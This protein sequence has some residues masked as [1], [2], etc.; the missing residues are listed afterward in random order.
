MFCKNCNQEI[1]N[2]RFCPF[3]GIENVIPTAEQPVMQQPMMHNPQMQQPVTQQPVMEQNYFQT[4]PVAHTTEVSPVMPAVEVPPVAPANV[5][6]VDNVMPN[7]MPQTPSYDQFVTPAQ[8]N[9]QTD[10]APYS[11]NQN[12]APVAPPVAP[13]VTQVMPVPPVSPVETAPPAEPTVTAQFNGYEQQPQ[14]GYSQQPH[15]GYAPQADNQFSVGHMSTPPQAAPVDYDKINDPG[16][17]SATAA[18]VWGIIALFLGWL[19]GIFALTSA[20]KYSRIGNGTNKGNANAGKIMGIIGIIVG[21]LVTVIVLFVLIFLG[22]GIAS[23]F[24]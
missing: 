16:K 19:P 15:T 4:T 22:I 14:M 23:L 8:Q 12:T 7:T 5:A 10:F 3:C 21:A 20:K 2:A 17:K 9:P 18:L 11:Q 1:G 13:P 6:Q 24:G